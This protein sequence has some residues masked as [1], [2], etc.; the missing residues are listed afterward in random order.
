MYTPIKKR[1]AKFKCRRRNKNP[2]NLSFSKL[3]TTLKALVV[4]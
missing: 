2:Q 4:V 3:R 1:E